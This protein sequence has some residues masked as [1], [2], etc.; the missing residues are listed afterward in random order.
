VREIEI[1]IRGF[2]L[3]LYLAPGVQYCANGPGPD[4]FGQSGPSSSPPD[5]KRS[6]YLALE[7]WVEKEIASGTIIATK[8]E[9][10]GPAKGV[11]MTRPLCPYPQAA[12]YKGI[13]DPNKAAN[14]TCESEKK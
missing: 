3:R 8:Y 9:D 11:K 5:P 2:F 4:A 13:G 14:F 1:G 6:L 12:K 7:Q 10:G